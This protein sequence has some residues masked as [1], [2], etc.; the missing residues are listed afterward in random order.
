M[1]LA[2]TLGVGNIAG[3]ATALSLGGAG[4]VLFMVVA[5]FFAMPLK[6]AEVVLSK[7]NAVLDARLRAHGG[8]M[9][10][11]KA[12]FRGR[13]GRVLAALFAVLLLLAT[14]T[15]GTTLQ[16]SAAAEAVEAAFSLSPLLTSGGMA[17][18]TLAVLWCG[19][20]QV[21]RVCAFLV[22]LLCLSF[23]VMSAVAL[24]AA[25]DRVPVALGQ[26]FRSALS[27]QSVGAGLL[28]S[29]VSRAVRYGVLRGMVSNEAG[30]GT[31]PIAHAAATGTTPVG[32]GLLGILEVFVD[33]VLLCTLTALVILVG[34]DAALGGVGGALAA[35]G[36]C[37]GA[38][39][40]PLLAAFLVVF[41]F[42]T[43]LC[44]AHYAAHALRFLGREKGASRLLPAATLVACIIG[45]VAAPAL[46]WEI[47][48]VL[49][50]LMALINISALLMLGREIAK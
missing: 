34:G 24:L 49:L 14:L 45:S 44:W 25:H 43:V 1:A 23:T 50:A 40:P 20:R 17:L 21:E 11:M 7:Q 38:A 31:A 19:T 12:L 13:L 35:Y 37:L 6:Y 32:Q 26:I 2:G 18:L 41:A 15:L 46:L 5:A 33:T 8:A 3:V 30:C 10:Y 9:Y 36:A 48:D 28:G 22:P 27:R 16:V 42:A 4:A 47:T 39:A 29:A